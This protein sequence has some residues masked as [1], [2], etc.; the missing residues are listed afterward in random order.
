VLGAGAMGCLF[1]ARLAESG[2]RVTLVDVRADQVDAINARGLIVDEHGKSRV[3]AVAASLP[4]KVTEPAD[5]I[6][7]FTKAF[8]SDAALAGASRAIGP[9]TWILT[10]QNGLG[11]V[12]KIRKHVD[13]HR[14]VV[15]T[16]TVPSDMV[17]LAH[18]ETRG[19]GSTKIMSVE[20]G[21]T[22]RLRALAAAL[23]GAGIPCEVS[24]RV[25]ESIWEKLAF[26]AAMNSLTAVTGLTVGQVGRSPAGAALAD[27]VATEVTA[28]AQ[29]QGIDA[30]LSAVR[31]EIATAFRE[32]VN[33]KPSMLQD[34]LAKRPTEI[35][36]INGAVAREA[37]RL[38]MAVPSTEVLYQ[39]VRLLE[40]AYP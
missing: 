13:A 9:D 2:Q 21:V 37:M 5:L 28:V 11:H 39:L 12:E 32:H 25:W 4:E 14:T 8:H 30:D 17:G 31:R 34:V 29:R 18:V 40:Q 10:L 19:S 38:G 3:V 36:H 26:N 7:L 1:G 33:H 16:T 23:T 22:D 27:R 24:E 35:E 6:L 15:G 20:G